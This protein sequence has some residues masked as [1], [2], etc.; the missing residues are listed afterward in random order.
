M[1]VLLEIF[2]ALFGGRKGYIIS[3]R[4]KNTIKC[5]TVHATANSHTEVQLSYFLVSSQKDKE[6][7]SLKLVKE[8]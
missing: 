6:S 1:Y 4:I 5:T 8:C 7:D 2:D 3:W